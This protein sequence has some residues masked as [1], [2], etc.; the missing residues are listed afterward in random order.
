MDEVSKITIAA[1]QLSIRGEGS[2]LILEV[3]VPQRASVV[4]GTLPG[5][6]SKWPEDA[7]N[8]GI[9][10]EG[11]TKFYPAVA[12]FS[13]PELVGPVSLGPGKHRLLLSTKVDPDS[14]RLFILVSETGDDREYEVGEGLQDKKTFSGRVCMGRLL[15]IESFTG[16]FQCGPFCSPFSNGCR[17]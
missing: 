8:Y 5:R 2:E 12:F 15:D 11:K 14:G 17:S 7:D 6:E 10:V 13:N 16:S 3:N 1:E 4:L 9:T